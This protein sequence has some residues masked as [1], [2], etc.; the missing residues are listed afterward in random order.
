MRIAYSSKIN[1]AKTILLS[2]LSSFEHG[3]SI[4]RNTS[5]HIRRA[6][7]FFLYAY[8]NST[9]IEDN[10]SKIKFEKEYNIAKY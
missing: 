5:A 8:K 6:K 10:N 3:V 4:L 2:K 1:I 7:I 9:M